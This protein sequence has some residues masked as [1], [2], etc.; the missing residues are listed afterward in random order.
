MKTIKI[1]VEGGVVQEVTIPK[2]YED[3]IDYEVI[4]LDTKEIEEN[5]DRDK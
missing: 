4:D 2:E 1:C 5:N 3:K